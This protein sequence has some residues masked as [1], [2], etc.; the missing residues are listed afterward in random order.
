MWRLGGA[1][2]GVGSGEVGDELGR[3]G[4]FGEAFLEGRF[5]VGGHVHDHGQG[6]RDVNQWVEHYEAVHYVLGKGGC[7]PLGQER[8][9]FRRCEEYG[10][11]SRDACGVQY[12]E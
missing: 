1:S 5:A 11:F 3:G 12:G 10:Q 6:S 7:S 9:V 2:W 4:D 8:A